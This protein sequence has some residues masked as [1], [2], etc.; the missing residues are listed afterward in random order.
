MPVDPQFMER[1][2]GKKRGI[3]DADRGSAYLAAGRENSE[4][5]SWFELWAHTQWVKRLVFAIG[6]LIVIVVIGTAMVSPAQWQRLKWQV[7]GRPQPT[8]PAPTTTP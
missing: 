8:Q 3:S 2:G 5:M 1:H 7:F 4:G 6:A